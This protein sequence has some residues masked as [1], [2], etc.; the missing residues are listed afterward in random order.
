MF[1]H[2]GLEA[3]DMLRCHGELSLL[4]ECRR[5]LMLSTQLFL[6]HNT[7]LLLALGEIRQITHTCTQ[8][9]THCVQKQGQAYTRACLP[10]A[11]RNR[12]DRTLT[13]QERTTETDVQHLS[14]DASN[15]GTSKVCS[16]CTHRR[17]STVCITK[18]G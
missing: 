15:E 18:R 13:P 7:L 11:L 10:L 14:G 9:G 6:L 2:E 4:Q 5:D 16:Q 17:Q 1:L 8:R 12:Q 3:Y